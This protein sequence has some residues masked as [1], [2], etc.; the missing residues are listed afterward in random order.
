MGVIFTGQLGRFEVCFMDSELGVQSGYHT[1]VQVD[2]EAV[3]TM[4]WFK[5]PP[6]SLL[7]V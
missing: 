7:V 2:G 4:E 3:K 5:S 1:V 6:A